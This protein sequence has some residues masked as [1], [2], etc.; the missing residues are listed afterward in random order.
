MW[1]QTTLYHVLCVNVAFTP[2]TTNCGG[3]RVTQTRQSRQAV[4]GVEG[5]LSQ[6][7]PLPASSPGTNKSGI[8]GIESCLTVGYV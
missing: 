2:R 8:D 1:P 7:A 4:Y 6:A 3:H 5:G